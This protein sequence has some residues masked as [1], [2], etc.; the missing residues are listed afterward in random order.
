MAQLTQAFF[1]KILQMEGGYQ[2]L[3]DDNG[4]YACGQL[5]GTNMGVSAVALSQWW[6]R[7]PTVAEMKGLSQKQAFDFY[8]WYFNQTNLYPIESQELFEFLANN[9][10]GSPSGAAKVE[11]RVL[12]R[13]GYQMPVDGK[14]GPTTVAAL[15]KA[16]RDNPARLWNEIRAE[17]IKYLNSINKP[18]FLPGWMSR[19]NRHYP[20]KG[21]TTDNIYWL[22][23]L[24]VLALLLISKK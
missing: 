5:I 14:R 19:L 12:N 17:W 7:C 22:A 15:N 8:A 1:N 4:N 23:P 13:L 20:I 24:A 21:E 2:S 18:Q 3:A 10:M 6:G 9:T 11:Q 16:W